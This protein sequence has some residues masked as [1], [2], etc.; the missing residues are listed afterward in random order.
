MI[1]RGPPPDVEIPDVPPAGCV[2]GEADGATPFPH[3]STTRAEPPE[4]HI[5]PGQDLVVLPYSRGTTGFAKGVMLTHRN[6]VANLVQM[7][8]VHHVSEEDRLIACLPFFHIYG[9]VV[10]MNN[11]LRH[12]ATI[13]TMPKF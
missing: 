11:G 4:V 5:D 9:Q 13:V 3:L 7:E 6:I 1:F 8:P 12:G 10:I 2:L